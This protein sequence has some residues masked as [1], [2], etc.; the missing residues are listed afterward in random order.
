MIRAA[1]AAGFA[2]AIGM[3]SVGSAKAG[4]FD[5]LFGP[6]KPA[7]PVAAVRPVVDHPYVTIAPRKKVVTKRVVRRIQID[8]KDMM[9]RTID[10]VK[11]PHW[12]LEDPTLKKGD[13]LV[14]NDR[15]LVFRGGTV[16]DPLAYVSLGASRQLN[17]SDRAKVA[18]MTR[19]QAGPVA[20]A[21][22]EPRPTRVRVRFRSANIGLRGGERG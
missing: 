7:A 12:Y 5:F 20:E 2:F 4:L 18:A 19:P 9:A 3:G 1:F 22:A 13:I 10:P 11:N 15:V 16:G 8:P 6:R 21:A 17:K 14:L